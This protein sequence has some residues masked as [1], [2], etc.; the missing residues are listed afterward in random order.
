MTVRELIELLEK[1]PVNATVWTQ[2]CDC[3]A[4]A[5]DVELRQDGKVFINRDED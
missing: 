5:G 3:D 1:M 2:G 4:L